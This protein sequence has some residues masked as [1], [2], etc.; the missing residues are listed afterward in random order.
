M[1]VRVSVGVGIGAL[2]VYAAIF[3]IGAA[4]ADDSAGTTQAHHAS[5]KPSGGVGHSKRQPRTK[6]PVDTS[7]YSGNPPNHALEV[8]LFRIWTITTAIPGLNSATPPPFATKGLTV[9]KT[10][11]D[12]M[13]VYVLEPKN[14]TSDQEIIALHGGAYIG[15]IGNINWITYS[16]IARD[17]GATVIVPVY[18]LAPKETA[19]TVVPKVANLISETIVARG[20]DNVSIL[21][22]SAGG[23]LAL[24]A[25]QQLVL[26]GS[27]V[28][29][30]MVLASPW[31]DATVSDP[32]SLTTHDELL[33]VGSLRSAGLQWAGNLD[34]SN[35]LVSPIN[36]SLEGLPT[37][38]VWS[39][40]SD[41]LSPQ[42]LRLRDDATALGLTNFTFILRYGEIHGWMAYPFIPTAAADRAIIA[43]QLTGR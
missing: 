12:G 7:P 25:V 9:T 17:T 28:P 23:G 4:H 43:D 35:P 10:E 3:G 38:Y 22:E 8:A 20:A 6:P 42:T 13:P 30:R 1:S 2:G 36:G 39:S 29:A 31:L 32:A 40:S 26:A 34:P 18:P 27:A 37:T 16:D 5:A 14:S 33:S 11:S 15:E 19:A 21:G 41:R 24:A